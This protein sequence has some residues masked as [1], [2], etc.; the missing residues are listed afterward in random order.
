MDVEFTRE[1]G[2]AIVAKK[3]ASRQTKDACASVPRAPIRA[4]FTSIPKVYFFEIQGRRIGHFPQWSRQAE[5]L[6]D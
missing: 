5:T 6:Y 4:K 1:F 3:P 2:V